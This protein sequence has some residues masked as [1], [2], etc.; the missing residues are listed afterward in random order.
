MSAE[1]MGEIG[2]GEW[3]PTGEEECLEVTEVWFKGPE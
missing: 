1:K 2:H 3:I